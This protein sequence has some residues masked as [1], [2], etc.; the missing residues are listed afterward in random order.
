M[1]TSDGCGTEGMTTD[2]P[3]PIL[4]FSNYDLE[5][6][7]SPVDA[8]ML[9]KLL[10]EADYDTKKT[11]FLVD[12]FR[13]GFSLGYHGEESVRH[14]SKNLRFTI[15]NKTILWNKVMKEVKNLRYAG[16]Y[17]E[18]P[19]EFFIQSPIGLVPKDNGQNTRLIF[20]LS[21]L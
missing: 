2:N 18:P 10:N 14:K 5:N 7:F 21:H 15:G 3:K 6:I 12:G 17:E 8:D 1:L 4:Q 19:F 11:T 20:H 16:P 9:E 13:N